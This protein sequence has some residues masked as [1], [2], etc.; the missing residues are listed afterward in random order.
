MLKLVGQKQQG[1]EQLPLKIGT[2]VEERLEII[3]VYAEEKTNDN[4]IG[5]KLIDVKDRHR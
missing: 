5:E 1:T 2:D 4:T 3:T